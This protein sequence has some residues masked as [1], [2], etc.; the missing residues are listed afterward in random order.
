MLAARCELPAG[1]GSVIGRVSDVDLR[2]LRVFV[3][4]VESGGFAVAT[5]QLN[6]AESTISQHM[7]DLERRLGL[8]LCE[9]GRA[10]FRLTEA[11][12]EVYEA[13]RALMAEMDGF[14][15]RLAALSSAV[16]GRFAI[17]LPDAI[18]TLGDGH[19]GAGL[20]RFLAGAPSLHPVLSILSPREL[21]R[22]V[23][24]GRL[25]C[26]V[27][28]EHR[29]VAGLAYRPLFGETNLLFCGRDHPLFGR[30]DDAI[31]DEAVEECPRIARGY[32]EGFDAHLFAGGHA[33]TVTETEGAA[34]LIQSGRYLGFLPEHYAAPWASAGTMRAVRPERYA[35]A[36]E[37]HLI[38]RRDAR[39]GT[40]FD[41]L[42]ACL[43][44][45]MPQRPS[46]L[47]APRRSL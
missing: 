26:A 25:A 42:A 31:P 37:F 32:L 39:D 33:A 27:A 8:R 9:R 18:A 16:P 5:A 29:R 30:P 41:R 36:T 34:L 6:V 46:G 23:I 3:T 44:L 1:G 40:L 43:A 14:R 12:Q 13:T 21:E 47:E 24:E 17:G 35:F 28:P 4:V 15:D 7:S 10:G 19:V 20:G 2:L 11:G 22:G 45:P 38:T